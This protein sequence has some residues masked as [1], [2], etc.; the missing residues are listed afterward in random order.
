VVVK[1]IM[2]GLLLNYAQIFRNNKTAIENVV[3]LP[4]L[5]TIIGLIG[6]TF[7]SACMLI[8]TLYPNDTVTWFPYTV[9]SIFAIMGLYIIMWGAF[10]RIKYDENGL[11]YRNKFG[12]TIKV[13][14][15]DIIRI[16]RTNDAVYLY[17]ASR[18]LIVYKT[19]AYGADRFL[20]FI[21]K[22]ALRTNYEKIK[23]KRTTRKSK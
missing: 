7:F 22:Y 9:F 3:R 16:R 15:S 8:M 11:S 17:T 13:R 4:K 10:W 23:E 14:Y 19:M 20:D 2:F 5:Y 6:F 21:A 12:R 1:D 18:K